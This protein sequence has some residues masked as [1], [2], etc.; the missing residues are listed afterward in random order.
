MKNNRLTI[1]GLTSL[2]G[3]SAFVTYNLIPDSDVVS[4]STSTVYA[5]SALA[6]KNSDDESV[7]IADEKTD[8]TSG[9]LSDTEEK[10]YGIGSVSKVYVTT[11]V[12][13]LVDQGKVELD[14]PITEYIPGF[15]MADERYKDI[16]VRMLMNHT[17]GIMGS[18]WTNMVL[19]DDCDMSYKDNTLRLFSTQRLKADPGKYAAYCNDG[20]TLLELIVEEVSGMSYT[21]YVDKNISAKIGAEH[22]GT[23]ENLFRDPMQTEVV[24]GS[25]IPVDY[26]YCMALGSGGI[27][28][29]ATE[30]ARFG[31]TFFTGDNTLLSEESKSEM[32]ERWNEDGENTDIYTD[33]NGLG[34]DYVETWKCNGEDIKVISKGGDITLQ[35][36]WLSV[37]PDEDISVAVLSAGGTSSTNRVLANALTEV[38]LED[39]GKPVDEQKAK[40]ISFVDTIPEEYKGYEGYYNMYT[41]DGNEIVYISCE[42]DTMLI[43]HLYLNNKLDYY[44]YTEEDNFERVDEDGELSAE[45]QTLYFEEK[46][47]GVY[48]KADAEVDSVG[49]GKDVYHLNCGE[50]LMP[51]EVGEEA[52]KALCK[53]N[54]ERAVLYND[55]Y[56]SADYDTPFQ[57]ITASEDLMGYINIGE[58]GSFGD[59]LKIENGTRAV[60]FSTIESSASRDIYDISVEKEK[61]KAGNE[62]TSV[63]VTTGRKYR[64]VSE[65][66][67]LDNSVKTVDLYT[68]EASWFKIGDDIAGGTLSVERPENSNIYV[69]NKYNE[70]VYSTHMHID[71]D[72]PLP[73]GG[74]IVFL[75]EDGGTIT[76]N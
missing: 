45:P 65:L 40:D 25:N 37:V 72:I 9:K 35:H 60:A 23:P 19:Y 42:E 46:D 10:I 41:N 4:I 1:I 55:K 61:L 14:A 44:K 69:Y 30:V 57:I 7:I 58:P 75:G 38:I 73:A 21:E 70:M 53:L 13:Q 15:T 56:T 32:A 34:W 52:S 68:E 2:L 31:S 43:K 54:D 51:N 50:R 74:Y 5:S 33:D 76:I 29:T 67:T 71:N 62:I 66:Q 47:G 49:L 16:T 59:L 17:S 36:A 24:V 63:N 28:S 20:F 18:Y 39:M 27:E 12:M 11:A 6:E 48:I 22:T 26:N 8:K 64:M 3:I